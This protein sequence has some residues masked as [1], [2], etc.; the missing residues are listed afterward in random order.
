MT[1]PPADGDV[2]ARKTHILLHAH[3]QQMDVTVD[4]NLVG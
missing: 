3:K 4:T 2:K 1:A